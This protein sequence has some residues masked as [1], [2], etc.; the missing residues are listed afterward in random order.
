MTS[1]K[2]IAIPPSETDHNNAKYPAV[3]SCVNLRLDP[4]TGHLVPAPQPAVALTTQARPV[5]EFLHPNGQRLVLLLHDSQLSIYNADT[6]DT[7]A[8]AVGTLDCDRPC[9]VRTS[10]LQMTV[11]TPGGLYT[12]TFSPDGDSATLQPIT[13]SVPALRFEAYSE[14]ILSHTIPAAT[15]SGDYTGHSTVLTD[16]DLSRLTSA[17]LTAY[18]ELVE[19]ARAAGVW[20]QPSIM[21]FRCLDSRGNTVAVGAP[22]LVGHSAGFGCVGSFVASLSSDLT[23]R[24]V[25][26][27]SSGVYR[28]RLC[29]N[30]S[31]TSMHPDVAT[32]V[33]ESTPPLHPVDFNS[34]CHAVI[35]HSS[36]SSA[37][38][39][40]LPG[41]SAGMADAPALRTAL[42]A[43]ILARCTSLY[44]PI[45]TFTHDA[46]ATF[47]LEIPADNPATRTPARQCS[48]AI[49]A[50]RAA[51]IHPVDQWAYAASSPHTFGA[52]AAAACGNTILWGG[53]TLYPF[54]GYSP[55]IYFA[56][57]AGRS[58][59]NISSTVHFAD[60]TALTRTAGGGIGAPD[61]V[62]PMLYYPSPEAV[63]ITLTLLANGINA[64]ATF[65][66]TPTADRRGAAW[67]A[68]GG[69][70]PAW[71]E[72]ATTVS[73]YEYDD[74]TPHIVPALT[75]PPANTPS[76]RLPGSVATA[77]LDSP[78]TISTPLAVSPD[79]ITAIRRSPIGDSAFGY[80]YRR[81]IIFASDA[82]F[83]SSIGTDGLI[84]SVDLLDPRPLPSTDALTETTSTTY[85]LMA[86]LGADLVG[87]GRRRVTT[88]RRNFGALHTI[89]WCPISSRLYATV[90]GVSTQVIT[91]DGRFSYTLSP[92]YGDFMLST[93][94]ALLMTGSIGDDDTPCI[95]DTALPPRVT[96]T[97]IELRIL[98]A[99]T[100]RSRQL[101]GAAIGLYGNQIQGRV[102][103][104]GSLTPFCP[105]RHDSALLCALDID[106]RSVRD[107]DTHRFIA[108]PF[109]F[110]AV[111]I[112]ANISPDC[113]INQT[114][115]RYS[116]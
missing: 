69:I 114:K 31:F 104:S 86:I 56:N 99:F 61:R 82:T 36:S 17:A 4:D 16:N 102:T 81:F 60:G 96:D 10:P 68:P 111:A 30:G 47:P 39:Y 70:A 42:V 58:G 109:P 75:I 22:T 62:A 115:L 91:P 12:L 18:S 43:D 50:A 45:A 2:I 107:I 87:I 55:L 41:T 6:P 89:G 80:A 110:I 100:P 83:V 64:R 38:R 3:V 98:H 15:L 116:G 40:T 51:T 73:T 23:S 93:P 67:I 21:R 66:L 20:M 34:L 5:A 1:P 90:P 79:S 101:C 32:I 71:S 88:L 7:P 27:L 78:A 13:P 48:L 108:R 105:D 84:R 113:C 44:T 26:T 24:Q 33:V 59:Y 53:L 29:F 103:V 49:A 54:A 112:K 94:S 85:P 11:A 37:I 35:E 8:V 14:Q 9:F 77:T 52:T 46:N 106:G 72:V 28:L 92:H 63:S 25:S 76:R 65:P 57:F 95:F 97:D 19:K 74:A